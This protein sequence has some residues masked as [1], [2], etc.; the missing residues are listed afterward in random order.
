MGQ[1]RAAWGL[2]NADAARAGFHIQVMKTDRAKQ[3]TSSAGLDTEL[4]EGMREG[5]PTRMAAEERWHVA[6][7]GLVYGAGRH[8][9]ENRPGED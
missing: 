9:A 3:V 5:K 2:K 6:N 8:Q 1:G 4:A 7:A